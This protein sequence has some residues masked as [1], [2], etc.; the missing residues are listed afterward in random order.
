MTRRAPHYAYYIAHRIVGLLA[1]P[2]FQADTMDASLTRH[3]EIFAEQLYEGLD[4]F[5]REQLEADLNRPKP[6]RALITDRVAH[7][8]L[9]WVPA[10]VQRLYDY[11]RSQGVSPADALNT[12]AVYLKELKQAR[13]DNGHD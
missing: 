8:M 6:P 2:R 5:W 4:E 3:V 11:R 10:P 13:G 12:A 1:D 9:R 7:E